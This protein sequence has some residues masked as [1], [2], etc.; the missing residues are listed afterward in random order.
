MKSKSKEEAAK[1]YVESQL[2]ILRKHGTGV[3][4]SEKK[5]QT[6]LKQVQKASAA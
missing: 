3:K 1:A 4:L 2:E 6:I 5:Y